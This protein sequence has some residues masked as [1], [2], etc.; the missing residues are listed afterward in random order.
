ML[1]NRFK[2]PRFSE[3][4]FD[5]NEENDRVTLPIF[6]IFTTTSSTAAPLSTGLKEKFPKFKESKKNF[7]FFLINLFI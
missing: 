6:R 1:I 7:L 5:R 2:M 4:S 3:Y